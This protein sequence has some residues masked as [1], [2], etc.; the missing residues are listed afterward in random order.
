VLLF[1][2][3]IAQTISIHSTNKL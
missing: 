1:L 3:A 2:N